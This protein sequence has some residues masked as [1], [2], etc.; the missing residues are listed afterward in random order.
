MK[1][2]KLWLYLLILGLLAPALAWLCGPPAEAAGVSA[3]IKAIYEKQ[4]KKCHGWDGKG[5]TAQGKKLNLHDWT[6]AQFQKEAKDEELLKVILEGYQDPKNPKR[7]MKAYKGVITESQAREL[8]QVVR[9]YAK[10][11]GPFPGEK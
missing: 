2:F 3:E 4:C 8:V 7:K 10:A 1:S 6:S 11:P 9:A 5:Q